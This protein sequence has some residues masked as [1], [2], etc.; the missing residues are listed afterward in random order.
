[1]FL[2]LSLRLRHIRPRFWGKPNPL[3]V[4]Q[5]LH[6]RYMPLSVTQHIKTIPRVHCYYFQLRIWSTHHVIPDQHTW[7]AVFKH[8]HCHVT[9][10]MLRHLT[11]HCIQHSRIS[12]S[13]LSYSHKR[14]GSR[15]HFRFQFWHHVKQPSTQHCCCT[16]RVHHSP[17]LVPPN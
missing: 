3:N 14:I 7:I 8:R 13:V 15:P 12:H 4:L 17:R 9:H 2:Y 10:N 16:A 11:L 1:M 5:I 6:Q